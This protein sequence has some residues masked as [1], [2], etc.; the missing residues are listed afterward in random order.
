MRISFIAILIFAGIIQ[1][2]YAIDNND[3]KTTVILAGLATNTFAISNRDKLKPCE[4][5]FHEST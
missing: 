5:Q 4:S 1:N 3:L 2:A